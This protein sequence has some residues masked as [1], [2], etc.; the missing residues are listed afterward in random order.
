[1]E[2]DNS[3]I[4]FSVY[5]IKRKIKLPPS[6]TKD[7]AEFVGILT[8]DGHISFTEQS[9]DIY[10]CGNSV[11]DCKYLTI[12]VFN[13]I[14]YLFNLRSFTYFRKNTKA[15]VVRFRSQAIKEY[16]YKMGYYKLRTNIKIPSWVLQGEFSS[17]FLRGL[18]DTDGSVF[19]SKKPGIEQYPCIELTTVSL[20]LAVLAKESLTK[21]GFRVAN[22]RS[23]KYKQWENLSFKVSLYGQK[24]LVKWIETIGF[25]N[26]YKLSRAQSMKNGAGVI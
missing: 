5:D 25:S 20:Q 7:L 13:L 24:N 12:H 22:V 2:F 15:I 21:L 10:V 18:I 11:T 19:V 9:H 3:E 6:P 17:P 8:G 26:L 4:K 16:F 23:Y 1:M 14:H